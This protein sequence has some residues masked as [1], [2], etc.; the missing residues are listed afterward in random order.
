MVCFG[1]WPRV[2][3]ATGMSAGYASMSGIGAV[4]VAVGEA[5]ALAALVALVAAVLVLFVALVLLL[6]IM[7]LLPLCCAGQGRESVSAIR[8]PDSG[9]YRCELDGVDVLLAK[10]SALLADPPWDRRNA[11]P[12]AHDTLFCTTCHPKVISHGRRPAWE[13]ALVHFIGTCFL[14]SECFRLLIVIT[15]AAVHAPFNAFT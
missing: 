11:T 7:T 10:Q 14:S 1:L 4:E 13:S 5:I 8:V 12:F 15:I 2:R 6:P 3:S 9:R